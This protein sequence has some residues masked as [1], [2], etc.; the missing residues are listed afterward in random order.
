[1]S[2]IHWSTRLEAET[3]KDINSL[4]SN[5][6]KLY[7]QTF[8]SIDKEIQS[9][10]G[11]YATNNGLSIQEVN[12]RL[13]P[14]ELKSAKEEMKKYYDD[15]DRLARGDSG[16]VSV[17]RLN[18]YKDELRL[19]SAK[20]YMAR[21]EELKINIKNILV[22][23]AIEEEISFHDGMEKVY[24]NS[25]SQSSY[26][27]DKVLGFTQGFA[28]PNEEALKKAIKVQWLGENY[29]DR[30]W[31]DKGKLIDTMET[32]FLQGL[33]RGQNPLKIAEEMTTKYNAKYS[34]MERLVRTEFIHIQNEATFNSYKNHGI[35][36][37]KYLADLSERT[38]PICGSLDGKIFSLKE[39]KEGVNYPVMHPRCRC[40]T[41]PYFEPDEIDALFEKS[42]RIAYDENRVIYEI[43]HDITYDEW[44]KHYKK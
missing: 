2:I 12:K 44:K 37:Y 41:I 30:I 29:S 10:Y 23:L 39:K 36:R 7:K 32:V 34:D 40:T 3:Q 19:Q 35:S 27:I 24:S 15:I 43:P 22:N 38:C 6:K 31:K 21:L 14:N 28:E 33:A 25:L 26:N 11:R 20:S 17:Q 9:F 13:N 4:I 8:K 5:L 1:M 16:K 42:S 18:K